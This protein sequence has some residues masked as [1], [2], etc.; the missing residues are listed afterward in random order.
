MTEERMQ[1]TTAIQELRKIVGVRLPHKSSSELWDITIKNGKIASVDPH[2]STFDTNARDVYNANNRLLAPSLCHAHVHLDKCFLLQ[3]PKYGDLQIESGD[4]SEAMQ[5]TGEA[6]SRFD[7][8]DLLKRG[9]LLIEESMRHGVTAMRA[10][11]EVDGVVQLKCLHAGLALKAHYKDKCDIQLCAFA[12]LPLFSG[13]DEGAEARELMITAAAEQ[14]VEVL[15]STPYVEDDESKSK[16]NARWIAELALKHGKHLD[17]HLD[18]FLEED[19][20]PLVWDVLK[21][22]K[23]ASWPETGGQQVTLGHCTR[24]TRFRKDDWLRLREK[25]GELPVSFV[26]LPTSDLFMM[27]TSEGLRGTLPIVE[28]IREYGL[29]A[30][31][32]INNVGN[33]FTP[34]GNCD[35]LSLAQLAVGLYQAGTKIDA[36]LLYETVSCRAKAVIG[37]ESPQ[38]NLAPGQS[39]DFVLFDTMDSGW[40]CRKSIVEVVYDAGTTRQT[41]LHN[42][43]LTP[44]EPDQRTATHAA[45]AKHESQAKDTDQSPVAI[46]ATAFIESVKIEF[47]E[48]SC[49]SIAIVEVLRTFGKGKISKRETLSTILE[50]LHEHED[51]GHSLMA[52]LQHADA[53]WDHQD[54]NV[55]PVQQPI[56]QFL[57]PAHEPK[58]RLPSMT[59]SWHHGDRVLTASSATLPSD[60]DHEVPP[61]F[62]EVALHTRVEQDRWYQ[63][64]RSMI[65]SPLYPR[66]FEDV[67][68]FQFPV[69]ENHQ[70]DDPHYWPVT[71]QDTRVD[72]SPLDVGRVHQHAPTFHSWQDADYNKTWVEENTQL[73]EHEESLANVQHSWSA[74]QIDSLPIG[75]PSLLRAESVTAISRH[76]PVSTVGPGSILT[77]DP[78]YQSGSP[79]VEKH[80]LAMLPPTKKRK[81]NAADI[82]AY[83]QTQNSSS[84][85]LRPAEQYPE[86]LPPVAPQSNKA[87]KRSRVEGNGP[88]VHALPFES[89]LTAVNVAAE[90]ESPIPQRRN[91]SAVASNLNAHA[92]AAELHDDTFNHCGHLLSHHT[93]NSPSIGNPPSIGNTYTVQS[94]RPSMAYP[95]YTG[96]E[97]G[98]FSN[99]P[100]QGAMYQH[101]YL[102]SRNP[103]TMPPGRAVNNY[104]PVLSARGKDEAT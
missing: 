92:I 94:M 86:Q 42:D 10:F 72:L 27:R 58:L 63:P 9:G 40:K 64:A 33:A 85:E 75:S 12:Q 21:I 36:E 61:A 87:S 98:T 14:D 28:L 44:D 37:R 47:G 38:L 11:V 95:S 25:I 1:S 30:A 5:M 104:K 26:G 79:Y 8:E 73:F 18:Y 82:Q 70:Q 45:A 88:Y 74:G 20:Q 35:P 99:R 32:S 50:N 43:C 49:E 60:F 101:S 77:P 34:Q 39:A 57:Q 31:I 103:V 3:D 66:P 53:R 93:G 100:D 62:S 89:L 24:L 67:S 55:L 76:Q 69:L 84:E 80:D 13:T 48:R 71:N 78:T 15:G 19:K 7:E 41:V 51:L 2:D 90:I 16:D 102:N 4:F 17:L 52:I 96:S 23:Q 68:S 81:R 91:D 29:N 59:S 56:P 83:P 54:F 6:K 22:L 46:L 97:D 65:S